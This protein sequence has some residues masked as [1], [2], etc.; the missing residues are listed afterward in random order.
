[1]TAAIGPPAAPC[2]VRPRVGQNENRA[3]V[4]TP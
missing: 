3:P 2:P 1:M 4:R